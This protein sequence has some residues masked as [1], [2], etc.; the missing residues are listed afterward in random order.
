MHELQSRKLPSVF[1]SLPDS[2]AAALG[3]MRPE[4]SI[5]AF[6]ELDKQGQF[7]ES[8]PHPEA[9][10]PS[11]IKRKDEIFAASSSWFCDSCRSDITVRRTSGSI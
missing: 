10:V 5:R 7:V 4:P 2:V 11:P 9:P 6:V 3:T 1:K 8:E